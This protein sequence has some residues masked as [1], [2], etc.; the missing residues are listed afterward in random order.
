MMTSALV[1]SPG[2]AAHGIASVRQLVAQLRRWIERM[3]QDQ[4]EAY[5]V[6]AEDIFDLERRMRQLERGAG[7]PGAFR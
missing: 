6:G 2:L 1:A 5:L 7:L 3:Q 4:R